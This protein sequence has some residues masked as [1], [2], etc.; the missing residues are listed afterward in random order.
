M[1]QKTNL[2]LTRNKTNKFPTEVIEKYASLLQKEGVSVDKIILFGSYAK[3]KAKKWSDID[4]CVVSPVFGK[5]P[6][7]EAKKLNNLAMQIDD[8]LQPLPFKPTDL[9]EKY[10]TLAHE[11]KKNGIEVKV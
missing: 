9:N 3:G 8:R 2:D 10:S 1:V 4:L 11:I 5:K 7:L 6:W